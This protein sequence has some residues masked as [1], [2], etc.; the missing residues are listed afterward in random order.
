LTVTD[1]RMTR[2]SITLQQG[3]DFV[4]D[5]LER[6]HGGELFVPKIPSY[7]ILDV[8]KAVA[9]DAEIEV[10]GIRPG[11]KL[12]ELMISEDDAR[13]TLEFKDY[14]LIQ[15]DFGWWGS[16]EHMKKAGGTFCEAGFSYRSDTNSEWL[17]IEDLQQTVS[18]FLELHPE[19]R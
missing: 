14:F 5:N 6:M 9:P 7:K 16:E 1:E 8:A 4:L 12:N 11:E 13:Q 19:Y 2:F 17:S 3:V 15:P 10:V 18:E